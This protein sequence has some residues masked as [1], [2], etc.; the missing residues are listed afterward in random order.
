M[1]PTGRLPKGGKRNTADEAAKG[2]PT[3]QPSRQPTRQP[4]RQPS[5]QPARPANDTAS[6]LA[7][8]AAN[9]AAALGRL[10]RRVFSPTF[11]L[12]KTSPFPIRAALCW[13]K[14]EAGHFRQL[15]SYGDFS[16][17][18]THDRRARTGPHLPQAGEGV[19]PDVFGRV[20]PRADEKGQILDF[21]PRRSSSSRHPPSASRQRS[22]GGSTKRATTSVVPMYKPGS[23]RPRGGSRAIQKSSM[24]PFVEA[25]SGAW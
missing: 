24:Q 25:R 21:F 19:G 15:H 16:A 5:G 14:H 22:A 23:Q 8:K 20:S 12:I 18:S 6:T 1:L 13:W 3:S 9:E 2:Q 10:G 17:H 7:R 4:T 11:V